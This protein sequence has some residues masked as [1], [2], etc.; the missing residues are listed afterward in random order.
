[1]NSPGFKPPS[2]PQVEETFA[3]MMR[4]IVIS[5]Q[6]RIVDVGVSAPLEVDTAMASRYL[7]IWDE[8]SE[9]ARMSIRA[10]LLNNRIDSLLRRI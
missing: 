7:S 3:D 9:S 10:L 8:S 2:P 1:M 4:L 6:A 5:R